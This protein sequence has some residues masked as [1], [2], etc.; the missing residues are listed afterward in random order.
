MVNYNDKNV[1]ITGASGGMGRVLCQRLADMGARLSICSND[2]SVLDLAKELSAKTK[3]FAKV[4]D[5]ACEESVKSFFEEGQHLALATAIL[6][7]GDHVVVTVVIQKGNH[8]PYDLGTLLQVCIDQA[9]VVSLCV[10]HAGVKG[11]FFS[12]IPGERDDF[13]RNQG[14]AANYF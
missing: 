10:L 12:K 4:F 14:F 13:H 11:G 2:E 9:D 8:V 3:V 5:V 1:I 7:G 6:I